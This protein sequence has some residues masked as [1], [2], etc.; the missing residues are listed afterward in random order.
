LWVFYDGACGVCSGATAW[1]LS[2][3]RGRRLRAEPVQ[4]AAAHARL[5]ALASSAALDELHVWSEA[6]GVESGVDALA[7]ILRELPRGERWAR[8]LVSPRVRPMASRAYRWLA[9]RRMWFGAASCEV[10]RAG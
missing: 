5:G 1:A 2:A 6:R 3:D 8:L 4:S 7:A 10:R 9:A